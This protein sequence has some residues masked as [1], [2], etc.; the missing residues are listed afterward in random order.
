MLRL[1]LALSLTHTHN[2]C[3]NTLTTSADGTQRKTKREA[4]RLQ[5]NSTH[6]CNTIQRTT[7]NG[8][9]HV[10]ERTT[11]RMQHT[12]TR[13][14]TLQHIAFNGTWDKRQLDC[15]ILQHTATHCTQWNMTHAAHC[16][17]PQH[18]A[19]HF[20]HRNMTHAF[21]Q[22][23]NGQQLFTRTALSN[24]ANCR[25]QKKTLHRTALTHCNTQCNALQHTATPYT[26][27]HKHTFASTALRRRHGRVTSNS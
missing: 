22:Q 12:A 3:K 20:T 2:I 13:C 14:N 8:T 16:N 4:P 6:D 17:T 5:H 21:D 11:T 15:N 24:W 1:S 27:T 25:T 7:L 10:D 19:T 9:R 26:I 23:S 18:T